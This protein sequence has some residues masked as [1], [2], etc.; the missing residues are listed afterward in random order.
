MQNHI[1]AWSVN[2][3]SVKHLQ[4]HVVNTIPILDVEM[5]IIRN[6]Y[7]I[8]KVTILKF[9]KPGYILKQFRKL[10]KQSDRKTVTFYVVQ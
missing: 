2:Q 4:L 1:Q 5:K 10:T 6:Y 3:L 7:K 9:V 8:E